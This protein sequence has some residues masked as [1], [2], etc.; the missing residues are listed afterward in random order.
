MPIHDWSRVEA[1]VFHD[2]HTTWIPDIKRTL[3]GGLLPPG[4]YAMVEQDTSGLILDVPT[5]QRAS[6]GA[7]GRS[8]RS[9]PPDMGKGM[10]ALADAPPKVRFRAASEAER[11]A[12]KARRLV[13]RHSSDDRIVA[14]IEIVSPGNKHSRSA[15]R[16]FVKKAVG[17]LRAGIHLLII[18]LLPPG[19]RD[20]Q[21]IHGAI[22]LELEEQDFALPPEQPLTLVSYIGGESKEAFIQ[23]AAVGE[24]L[25]VIPLFLEPDG[26]V[27]LPLEP[28]YQSAY[29]TVPPHWREVLDT[30]GKSD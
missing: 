8:H 6:N 20:P 2:F 1:G 9:V 17:Y 10:V 15:L 16:T 29:V 24:L 23:P 19:Q 21:G 7:S 13:V 4:Y 3:I 26:Y 28:S 5:L 11:Y 30:P 22:W 14:I 18:D 27:N 25:P 12:A